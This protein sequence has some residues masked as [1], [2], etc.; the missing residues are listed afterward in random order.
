MET[1]S[2]CRQLFYE[3]R[4]KQKKVTLITACALSF[5]FAGWTACVIL[6]LTVPLPEEFLEQGFLNP[7]LVDIIP[8]ILFLAAFL[9]LIIYL[10][11]YR[12]T[13]SKLKAY[14][15]IYDNEIINN[16]PNKKLKKYE[17]IKYKGY[18][19]FNNYSK[20]STI[21]L[22]FKDGSKTLVETRKLTEIKTAL[23][24]LSLMNK[25]EK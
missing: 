17:S 16:T 4:Q 19:I 8:I 20:V 23:D 18:K 5:I 7:T 2:Q 22:I 10:F 9:S 21:E 11:I 6:A 15:S 14:I 3:D 12:F 25:Q 24:Y 13:S 1:Q